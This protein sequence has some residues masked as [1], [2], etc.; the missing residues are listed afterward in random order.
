MNTAHRTINGQTETL[1]D[2]WYHGTSLE[3]LAEHGLTE[4]APH[5]GTFLTDDIRAAWS[6]AQLAAPIGGTPVLVTVRVADWMLWADHVDVDT[7]YLD[8]GG[9][10]AAMSDTL[11]TT[12]DAVL[13]DD[14]IPGKPGAEI[15]AMAILTDTAAAAITVTAHETCPPEMAHE[16][17]DWSDCLGDMSIAEII[18]E[19]TDWSDSLDE[20]S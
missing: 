19:I 15:L 11:G 6:Y 2:E 1:Y 3:T 20:I 16:I 8:H 4:W 14:G 7:N 18:D 9:D 13:I 12:E 17:D 10:A 5:A